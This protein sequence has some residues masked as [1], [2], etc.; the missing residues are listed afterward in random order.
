MLDGLDV[1]GQGWLRTNLTTEVPTAYATHVVG[2]H[3]G[4]GELRPP[5]ICNEGK[6]QPFG[7][8]TI[9]SLPSG[10]YLG[11]PQPTNPPSSRQI[12]RRESVVLSSGSSA[13]LT[14]AG[15]SESRTIDIRGGIELETECDTGVCPVSIKSFVLTTE[16]FQY[17]GHDVAE[18][19]VFGDGV[20]GTL[21]GTQLTIPSFTGYIQATLSDGRFATSPVQSGVILARWDV[22]QRQF[23]AAFAFTST[24][25]D[26]REMNLNGTALGHFD[27]TSPT[28][29]ISVAGASTPGQ[30]ATVECTGP[31]GTSVD[32]DAQS[33]TDVETPSHMK[34]AWYEDAQPIAMGPTLS[35]ASLPEGSSRT[36]QMIT[37]D[38]RGFGRS[39]AVTIDVAD[40]LPPDISGEEFCIWPPN[41]REV[42]VALA[43]DLHASATDVCSG[44]VDAS[45]RV[46]SVASNE[47]VGVVSWNSDGAC[48]SVRRLGN[49]TGRTYTITVEASDGNGNVVSKDLK[50]SIPHDQSGNSSCRR[51]QELLPCE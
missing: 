2:T 25:E 3:A 14:V 15:V 5:L 45:L 29:E 50:V 30:T 27:N 32:I 28:A 20:V 11:N 24:L 10:G 4:L 16:P 51:T 19:R 38:V 31:N 9:T 34:F 12:P 46:T 48:L 1:T 36:I 41:G 8:E 26:T 6:T 42:R 7:L 17:Q 33:S 37:S 13:L 21:S 39:D 18:V 40:T 35:L 43:D 23:V 47:G 49:G 44:D 22:V